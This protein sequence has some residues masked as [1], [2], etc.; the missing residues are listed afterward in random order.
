MLFSHE[1]ILK[2]EEVRKRANGELGHSEYWNQLKSNSD[3]NFLL[4]IVSVFSLYL[5]SQGNNRENPTE[6][7]SQE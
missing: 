3:R 2:L 4:D 1:K 7:N 5:S 6:I